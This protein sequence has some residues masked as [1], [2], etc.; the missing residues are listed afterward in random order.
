MAKNVATPLWPAVAESKEWGALMRPWED[1][2]TYIQLGKQIKVMVPPP[3]LAADSAID[4]WQG[5]TAIDALMKKVV[6]GELGTKDAMEQAAREC[7]QIVTEA[8]R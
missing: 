3:G 4:G 5:Y 6:N 8:M 2:A 7:D 1:Q